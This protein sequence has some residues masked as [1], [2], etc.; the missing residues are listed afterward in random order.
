MTHTFIF[1]SLH[2]HAHRSFT[3]HCLSL[4]LSFFVSLSLSISFFVSSLSLGYSLPALKEVVEK[5]TTPIDTI[6]S[7]ARFALN[8]SDLL[9][10]L[11]F[12]ASKGLGIINASVENERDEGR[13]NQL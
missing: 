10:Y 13:W 7:Y 8:N 9:D 3:S 1:L 11:P 12:F 2:A 6:L 4:F 5:S